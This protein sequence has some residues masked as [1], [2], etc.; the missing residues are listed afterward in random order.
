MNWRPHRPQILPQDL[1]DL[2]YHCYQSMSLSSQAVGAFSSHKKWV[3]VACSPTPRRR[4]TVKSFGN[5]C[6]LLLFFNIGG[7]HCC[8]SHLYPESRS[9]TNY[10]TGEVAPIG[11]LCK[12]RYRLKLQSFCSNP[13]VVACQWKKIGTAYVNYL[14][15]PLST[16]DCWEPTL[17]YRRGCL[18]TAGAAQG[19]TVGLW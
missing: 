1:M 11:V 15:F 17:P 9:Y 8:P 4:T 16:T 14:L 19:A 7:T 5:D 2:N 6:K 12:V 3:C 18:C 13:R 10:E